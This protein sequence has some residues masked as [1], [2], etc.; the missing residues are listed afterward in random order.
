MLKNNNNFTDELR[1]R[2][3]ITDIIN[4]YVSLIK[5]GKN[6]WGC[7]P[8]H[9]EKTASFS[10][11]EE[12]G[13]YHC[14]GCGEHGDVI[15]FLMK[16]KNLDFRSAINELAELANLKI[17]QYKEKDIK[18]KD[19]YYN[20]MNKITDIYHNNL[21]KKEN[22]FA[23][24]YLKKRGFSIEIIKKY[25]IGYSLKQNQIL[26][27][28]INLKEDLFYKLGIIRK[29]DFGKYDFFK[30]RIMFPIYDLKGNTVAFSGRSIDGSDPKYINTIDTE[31]FHK[32]K[33][34]FGLNFARDFIYKKNRS[35]LVEGQIDVI[36]MQTNGF[37]E[38]VAPLGTA[39]TEDHLSILCKL[40]R[41]I[42]FC[43]DG[44]NAGIKAAEKASS[45]VMPFLRNNS[46]IKFCFL[47]EGKD[48]DE[49]LKKING[50]EII[51]NLLDN[52]IP[53][54]DFLWNMIN[55][56][57]IT[58]SPGGRVQAE[59]FLEKELKKIQE[60]KLR[61]EYKKEFDKRKFENWYSWKKNK[62]KYENIKIPKV[63]D[64]VLETIGF[65]IK[66]YPQIVEKHFDFIK[67]FSEQI[68]KGE[69]NEINLSLEEADKYINL[70]KFKETLKDLNKQ[71]KELIEKILLG[72]NLLNEDLDRI[73]I[74]I[75]QIENNLKFL[76]VE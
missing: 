40:N 1:S 8:F 27:T 37:E 66:K 69:S 33:I 32:R 4:N 5:K 14:F 20:I 3:S 65:I 34:L 21:F 59:E 41:N 15:S 64:I 51:N 49:I 63:D 70:L 24:E 39:L 16:I 60:E 71:K 61:N 30:N 76:Q 18:E 50:K 57:Y 52:A 42:I 62:T 45:L 11:N 17:P 44:D 13:F 46:S 9:N 26:S 74:K 55:K 10:V 31:I 23:L 36:K 28:F 19:N 38:T 56:K 7:C 67:K 25:K 29:S 43:F 68:K 47:K 12:K 58:S 53:I 6:Y 54:E 22:E 48:P 2:L 72:N 35:I 73:N 75:K